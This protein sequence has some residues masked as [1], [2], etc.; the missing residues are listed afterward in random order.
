MRKL[1]GFCGFGGG[2]MGADCLGV[3]C[4]NLLAN[5]HNFMIHGIP[6]NVK[7]HNFCAKSTHS[8]SLM[9]KFV[10]KQHEQL[11]FT[12]IEHGLLA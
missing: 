11:N 4:S 2:L 9:A 10:K 6:C 1:T 12:E 3:F 8:P 7:S 5:L